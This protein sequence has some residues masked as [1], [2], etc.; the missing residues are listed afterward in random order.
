MK[1]LFRTIDKAPL[2]TAIENENLEMVKLLLSKEKIDINSVY[3]YNFKKL[4][5]S[6]SFILNSIQNDFFYLFN[7][8]SSIKMIFKT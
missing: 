4:K 5:Q 8:N 1:F 3:I 6:F 7:S 2:H